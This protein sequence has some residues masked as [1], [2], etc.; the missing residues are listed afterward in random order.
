MHPR[1]ISTTLEHSED[2]NKFERSN[3][4]IQPYF[5]SIINESRKSA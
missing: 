5:R 1:L 2:N 3:V 4:R